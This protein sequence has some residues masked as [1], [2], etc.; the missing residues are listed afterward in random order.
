[1][2]D[3]LLSPEQLA[4]IED[5]IAAAINAANLAV[6]ARSNPASQSSTDVSFL[7]HSY[8][9]F[10]SCTTVSTDIPF[11]YP[12][13]PSPPH[14]QLMATFTSQLEDAE[15][16]MALEEDT[17][18]VHVMKSEECLESDVVQAGCQYSANEYTLYGNSMPQ[19]SPDPP[20]EQ[21]LPAK[22]PFPVKQPSPAKQPLL[23]EQSPP[24]NLFL[25]ANLPD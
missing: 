9:P 16:K 11:F 5:M 13:I 21:P 10:L 6:N 1:M 8:V 4:A 7:P 12:D 17:W 14:D 18:I 19:T 25:P 24:M 23:E 22:Q 20:V 15:R 2:T 3:S